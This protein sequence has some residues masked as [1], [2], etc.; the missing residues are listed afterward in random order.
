ME[1]YEAVAV[2][3]MWIYMKYSFFILPLPAFLPAGFSNSLPFFPVLYVLRSG[4][5]GLDKQT[6]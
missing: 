3:D 2:L 1:E 4:F 5:P 6:K